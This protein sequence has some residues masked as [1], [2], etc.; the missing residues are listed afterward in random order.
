MKKI[1]VTFLLLVIA[2]FVKIPSSY[3]GYCWVKTE[4]D[5]GVK[6]LR[7]KITQN[8]SDV[9]MSANCTPP[10][11]SADEPG[12]DDYFDQVIMFYTTEAGK[13]TDTTTATPDEV[14]TIVL[15]KQIT[16]NNSDYN[17]VIGNTSPNV[18]DDET[19]YYHPYDP[20]YVDAF[21][22]GGDMGLV[23]IDATELSEDSPFICKED[24]Q[25]NVYFRNVNIL[26][27]SNQSLPSCIKNAGYLLVNGVEGT[28]N[29]TDADGDGYTTAAGD[30]D[31]DNSRVHPGASDSTCDDVDNNCNGEVDEE[32]TTKTYYLDEDGDGY[33]VDSDTKTACSRPSGYVIEDGDCDDDNDDINPGSSLC[34]DTTTDIDY[35]CDGTVANE[36]PCATEN[37]PDADGDGYDSTSFG[38]DDCDDNDANIHPDATDTCDD[39]TD[40]DCDG[41][42]CVETCTATAWY[43]DDDEDGYGD[44]TATATSECEQPTGYVANAQDC[45]D[46]DATVHPS[47]SEIC[48]VCSDPNDASTCT[49]DL[50]DQ[51]CDGK[52]DEGCSGSPYEDDDGDG[53]SENAGD[54]DDTD[55]QINPSATEICDDDVDNDCDGSEVTSAEVDSGTTSLTCSLTL[56]G[57]SGSS[58]SGGC[59]LDKN[60]VLWSLGGVNSLVL[61]MPLIVLGL[62]S[63][64][65]RS[66]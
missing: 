24:T 30:C 18:T 11:S 3:A 40:S 36:E 66:L 56:L 26:L 28:L 41:E 8:Y 49:L 19:S 61:L 47:A 60:R 63:I 17:L 31:D 48:G 7:Y 43:P 59:S 53:L 10:A 15:T 35:D 42:D 23:T 33:G 65:R 44:A 6:S 21:E 29:S 58:G 16:F 46:A 37:N 5:S 20:K 51:D 1:S 13:D 54:C 38:G 64:R 34:E 55:N 52:I 50:V 45:N 57:D 22:G 14:N 2:G 9:G 62:A 27:N 39:D 12:D 32:A 25:K 4:A